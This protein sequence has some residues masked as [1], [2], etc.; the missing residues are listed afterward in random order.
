MD[1][2]TIDMPEEDRR[3]TENK[4]LKDPLFLA[5]RPFGKDPDYAVHDFFRTIMAISRIKD[6]F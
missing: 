6:I 5:L 1:E 2:F 4:G 3:K